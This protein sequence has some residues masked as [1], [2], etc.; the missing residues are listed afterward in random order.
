M[1]YLKTFTDESSYET[2]KNSSEW[3][4]PNICYLKSSDGVAYGAYV[5]PPPQLA[6]AGDVAYWDGSKVKTTPYSKWNISLGTPVGVVVVP[7]GF[8][9][10]GKA[11]IVSLLFVD[12]SGNTSTSYKS[13]K[14]SN[15]NVDTKLTNFDRVPTTNNKGGTST[16]SN[17]TGYLPSDKF[18]GATSFVDPKA[19]YNSTYSL[20]PS[21]YLGESPNPEYYK[22]ILSGSANINALSDFNGLSNTQTLVGLGSDYVAANAAWKYKDG[23]S[24]LQWYLPAMGELGYIMPRFNEINNIITALGGVA[25]DGSSMFWSSSEYINTYANSL[26]AYDG[27]VGNDGKGRTNYVRPFAIL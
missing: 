8:A 10:D 21:P 25:V 9:P 12:A 20:I 3:V 5:P 11:R 18:T 4:T 17:G 19:K 6:L 2:F 27:I 1:K 13:M 14:W 22:E 26:S 7:E 16:G 15:I 23:A 24:N